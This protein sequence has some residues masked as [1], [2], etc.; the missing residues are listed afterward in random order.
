M[1]CNPKVDLFLNAEN[2]FDKAQSAAAIAAGLNYQPA[3]SSEVNLK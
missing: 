3:R 1:T 2:Q